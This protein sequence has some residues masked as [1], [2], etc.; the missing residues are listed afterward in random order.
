MKI[1]YMS[2]AHEYLFITESSEGY[3]Y[4]IYHDN[5]PKVI[6]EGVV[7]WDQITNAPV[8]CRLP[9]DTARRMIAEEN[10][11]DWQMGIVAVDTLDKFLDSTNRKRPAPG[12]ETRNAIRFVDKTYKNLFM[13][14]DGGTVAIVLPSGTES[15]VKCKY[16]DATH[17]YVNDDCYHIC[18]FAEHVERAAGKC[19][20]ETQ[21]TSDVCTWRVGEK[22]LV[23]QATDNGWDYTF[24]HIISHN[25]LDGGQ[26]DDTNLT[27]IEARE[28]ILEDARLD[29]RDRYIE[30]YEDVMS[31]VSGD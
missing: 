28:K 5:W 26:L 17:F 25:L 30:D 7:T 8:P 4:E 19:F 1:T 21:L 20:P 24:Y 2:R 18:E 11:L 3:V 6:K 12:A 27:I 23:L 31:L 22:H 29:N 10:G 9:L 14:P 16:I 15:V 13:L